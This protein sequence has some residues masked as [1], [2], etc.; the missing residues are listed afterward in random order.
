MK[1]NQV[2][3]MRTQCEW[4]HLP[5]S[6]SLDDLLISCTIQ[7]IE[8]DEM[9]GNTQKYTSNTGTTWNVQQSAYISKSIAH[10]VA[11]PLL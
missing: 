8:R 3:Y 10:A 6:Y 7:S 1:I 9:Q 5:C 11:P 2:K 4:N